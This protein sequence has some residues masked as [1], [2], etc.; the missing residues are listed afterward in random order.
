[1]KQLIIYAK[2]TTHH[3]GPDEMEK[4]VAPA[5]GQPPQAKGHGGLLDPSLDVGLDVVLVLLHAEL[6]PHKIA[7]HEKGVGEELQD[8]GHL[9]QCLGIDSM[10]F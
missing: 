8:R 6:R 9:R 1:M 7:A 4:H 2:C 3:S 10:G 5:D